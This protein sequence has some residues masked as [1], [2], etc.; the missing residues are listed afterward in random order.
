MDEVNAPHP[1]S[2]PVG[3][4]SRFFPG[5]MNRIPIGC[6]VSLA[7]AL[8][9]ANFSPAQSAAS[10]PIRD[11]NHIRLGRVTVDPARRTASFPAW[12]NMTNGLIEYAV[13]TDYGKT[14]ESLLVTLAQ[15]LDV[16]AAL[17]LLRAKPSGTNSLGLQPLTIPSG[18]AVRPSLSWLDGTQK[19]SAPLSQWVALGTGGASGTVTGKM[20]GGPW[21]FNGSVI[22]SEGFGAHFDGSLLALIRDPVAILNN[23]GPDRDDDEIHLAAPD[24]MPP[25]E[26]PVTVELR[27]EPPAAP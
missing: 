26:T 3:K 19:V 1:D 11:G 25:Y 4:G 20:S 6:L 9:P 16:Q 24:R 14:H 17:L 5:S 21:L 23:P 22:T 8:L 7:L 13:V 10:P 18:A 12:V 2:L 27:V 15:P